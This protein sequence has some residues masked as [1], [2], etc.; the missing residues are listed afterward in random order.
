MAAIINSMKTIVCPHCLQH[1]S[2]S[3]PEDRFWLLVDKNGPQPTGKPCEGNCWMWCG[4]A[5][6][7]GYGIYGKKSRRRGAHRMSWEYTY[8]EIPDGMYVCHKCDNKLCVNPDHLFLG[9]A[10]DNVRDYIKKGLRKGHRGERSPTSKLTEKDVVSIRT[11]YAS[12]ATLQQLSDK[13]G[14]HA[15]TVA[16]V[17][18]G[19]SWRHIG[20]H[21]SGETSG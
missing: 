1:I 13:Y 19:R 21:T 7:G 11:E 4:Q 20:T 9:T 3:E 14:V 6:T 17:V 12:G 15:T 18:H 8:G 16:S 2:V 5:M 10:E